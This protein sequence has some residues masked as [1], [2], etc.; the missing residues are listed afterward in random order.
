[1]TNWPVIVIGGGPSG[2]AAAIAC[3]TSGLA[4]LLLNPSGTGR[5]WSGE[6]IPAGGFRLLERAFGPGILDDTPYLV[7]HGIY[8]LWGSDTLFEND[9]LWNP[10]GH[11]MLLERCHFDSAARRAAERLGVRILHHGFRSITRLQDGWR[12]HAGTE[13][14]ETNWVIDASGRRGVMA[15]SLGIQSRHFDDQ[16]ALA[17]KVRCR[18]SSNHRVL[19]ESSPDGW[20]YS[21]PIP[22]GER[23][24]VFLTDRDLIPVGVSRADWWWQQYQG[25]SLIKETSP[26]LTRPSRL[27]VLPAG[28]LCRNSLGGDA[29]CAVGDAAI[30]WDPLSSQGLVTGILMGSRSGSAVAGHTELMDQIE[31]DYRM[32]LEEH[33]S[34]RRHFWNHERRWATH[35]FWQRRI[36]TI[37]PSHKPGQTA[38]EGFFIDPHVGGR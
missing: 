6:S 35:P 20:W 34:L 38:S 15:R 12:L 30:A 28:T 24:V 31:Q 16:V 11:G 32:L 2:C 8:G 36:E 10:S 25:T 14:Y 26:G 27:P 17:A 1:M 33:L 19:I 7:S 18:S 29:W 3:Q 13:T 9:F 37:D 23:V 21:C 5:S 22:S 4:T